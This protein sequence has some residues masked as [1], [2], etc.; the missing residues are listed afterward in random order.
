M[1]K[2]LSRQMSTEQPKCGL[3]HKQ[4]KSVPIPLPSPLLWRV[5]YLGKFGLN[6][7]VHSVSNFLPFEVF[8]SRPWSHEINQKVHFMWQ[9][10][11]SQKGHAGEAK[12]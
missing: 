1:L 6:I 2:V 12:E 3:L 9:T 10:R 8:Q 7:A 4:Q 5:Q 11:G